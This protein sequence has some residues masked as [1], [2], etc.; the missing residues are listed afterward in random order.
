MVGAGIFS[1]L[2]AAGEVAGSAVWLSFILAGAVAVLQGY[3]FAKIGARYPSGGRPARVRRPR[4]RQRPHHGRHRLAGARRE[5]DHH[6]DGGGLVRQLRGR[7]DRG[8]GLGVRDEGLRRAPDRRD[9]GPQRLRLAGR[10]EGPVDRRRRRDRHPVRLRGHDPRHGRLR[11]A[12]AIGLSAA[13][14]HRRQRGAD[15]LRL[16]RASA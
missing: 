10:R 4:L 9:V 1:L 6:R 5:R 15:V 3:S 14:R 16:P 7:R 11:A 8:G 12:G 2:G 13:R